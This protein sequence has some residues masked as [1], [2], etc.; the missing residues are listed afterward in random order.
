MPVSPSRFYDDLAEYY[1]LIY[2][3]WERSMAR[4]GEAI[5][6]MLRSLESPKPKEE[7][8]VL[9]IAAGIGTQTLPLAILGYD[10]TARDLSGGAVARLSGTCPR[11]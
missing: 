8:R 2:P 4:Q 3:D 7:F 11:G 9:D 1:D 10:V 5:D 6:Q